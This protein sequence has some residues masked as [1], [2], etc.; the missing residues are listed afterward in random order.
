MVGKMSRTT[1]EARSRNTWLRAGGMILL[2]VAAAGLCAGDIVGDIVAL[3]PSQPHSYEQFMTAVQELA[4]S[5]RITVESIGY[6]H[7]GRAV[8]L[9]A[10]QAPKNVGLNPAE[11]PPCL[12]IV[13]RQHGT[14]CS[15]TEAALALLRYFATTDDE[16]CQRILEQLTIVVV[17]MANPDGVAASRRLNAANVDLNRDWISLSQPETRAVAEAL[18]RWQPLAAIDMHELPAGSDKPAY[19]Q[20]FVETIGHDDR[21]ATWLSDDCR[22]CSLRLADWMQA[23]SLPANFYYDYSNDSR[24][25][26]HRYFGLVRGIPAYL[27]EAKTGSGHPL[28]QRTTFHVLGALVVGNY[29][30]HTYYDNQRRGREAVAETPAAAQQ[31]PSELSEATKPTLKLEIVK[32]TEGAVVTGSVP[33]V[34]QVAGEGFSYVTFLIDGVLK[35]MTTCAPY[36]YL[37]NADDYSNGEHRIEVALCNATGR[38]LLSEHCTIIVSNNGG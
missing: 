16:T 20:S 35:A 11:G 8:V 3:A 34:V 7:K 23:Y 6:T 14:E 25:L 30:I 27:F 1:C 9:V 12:F 31:E 13:A 32:P 29:L 5:P 19:A 37:L 2:L 22:I 28:E 4:A 21:I 36:T 10:V 38:P 18:S 17:P 15:G 24:K 33:V 26:C